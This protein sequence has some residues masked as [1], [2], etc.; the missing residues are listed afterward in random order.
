MKTGIRVSELETMIKVQAQTKMDFTDIITRD[1]R[2]EAS[3]LHCRHQH[4]L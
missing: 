2:L 4:R 3:P 1:M